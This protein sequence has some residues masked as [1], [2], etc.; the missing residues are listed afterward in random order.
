MAKLCCNKSTPKSQYLTTSN[1]TCL[2]RAS[3]GTQRALLSCSPGLEERDCKTTGGEAERNGGSTSLKP[4]VT[5]L[6]IV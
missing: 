2:I 1:L 3:K 6:L 5:L 4:E